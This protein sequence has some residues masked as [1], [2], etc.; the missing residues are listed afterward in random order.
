MVLEV[1]AGANADPSPL[2]VLFVAP[3]TPLVVAAP[4]DEVGRLLL[5]PGP[6]LRLLWVHPRM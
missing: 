2:V 4:L 6:F 1:V 5:A 3:L